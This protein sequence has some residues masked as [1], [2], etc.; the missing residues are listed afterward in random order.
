ML[1]QPSSSTRCCLC[2][3]ADSLSRRLLHRIAQ[4]LPGH[5]P[6]E[7]AANLQVELLQVLKTSPDSSP[8]S[9]VGASDGN[10]HVA[11]AAQLA[12]PALLLPLRRINMSAAAG[13]IGITQLLEKN[14]QQIPVPCSVKMSKRAVKQPLT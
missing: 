12:P 5:E 7:D 2:H 13:A 9:T 14:G 11:T 10:I 3:V 4:E 6:R 8:A 1:K